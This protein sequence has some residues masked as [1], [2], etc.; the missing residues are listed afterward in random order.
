MDDQPTLSTLYAGSLTMHSGYYR[1]VH[2]SL[3]RPAT[4]TFIFKNF[5]LPLC[6]TAGCVV[7]F[8]L[9]M[10]APSGSAYKRADAAAR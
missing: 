4:E 6:G 5:Y 10:I 8:H 3:H 7:S 1:V 2:S 9:I